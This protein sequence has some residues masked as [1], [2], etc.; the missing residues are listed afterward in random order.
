M[1]LWF[2]I[3]SKNPT[4]LLEIYV[5]IYIYTH[6]KS[7][8]SCLTP[9]DPM[10]CKNTGVGCYAFLQGIFPTQGLNPC[11]RSSALAGRFFTARATWEA[12]IYICVCVCVCVCVC[13]HAHTHI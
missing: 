2:Q 8:Q 12:H 4:K 6:A 3:L 11:L 13:I 7:L 5:C 10:D 1:K 9:C